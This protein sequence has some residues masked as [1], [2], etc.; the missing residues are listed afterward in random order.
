MCSKLIKKLSPDDL[1][2]FI[3]EE[4]NAMESELDQI[5]NSEDLDCVLKANGVQQAKKQTREALKNALLTKAIVKQQTPKEFSDLVVTEIKRKIYSTTNKMDKFVNCVRQQTKRLNTV[6]AMGIQSRMDA[7]QKSFSSSLHMLQK[8]ELAAKKNAKQL[9]Q[10]ALEKLDDYIDLLS[11]K[12]KAPDAK[13]VLRTDASYVIQNFLRSQL[14]NV[15]KNIHVICKIKCEAVDYLEKVK[16]LM[17]KS[18]DPWKRSQKKS[19][20]KINNLSLAKVEEII[21]QIER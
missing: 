1:V 20:T 12:A 3:N 6:Q 17:Y 8:R 14:V 11:K 9:Q 18:T 10:T 7:L 16:D 15:E 21:Q 2:T 5:N 19:N 4:I 13:D